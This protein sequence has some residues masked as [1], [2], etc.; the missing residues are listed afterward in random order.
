MSSSDNTVL[1]MLSKVGVITEDDVTEARKRATE[2]GISVIDALI[3][4]EVITQTDVT[5]ALASAFGMEYISLRDISIQE[6][7]INALPRD[8][9]KRY[10]VVPVYKHDNTLEIALS[11]P[12][13]V[14][15]VDGLRYALKCDIEALVAPEKEIDEAILRY[16]GG[17]E[18][19]VD[20]MLQEITQGEINLKSNGALDEPEKPGTIEDADAPIIRLAQLILNNAFRAGA[21]D[22]H[23]EPLEKDLRIRHRIDG[24]MVKV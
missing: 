1:D 18:E 9:A 22:I 6:E 20:K 11:D 23:I 5:K 3:A 14:D 15:V 4:A 24:V 19:T 7:V 12:L 16:Y 21:S 13:D 10:R 8:L 17:A 2:K